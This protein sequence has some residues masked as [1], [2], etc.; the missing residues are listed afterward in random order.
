MLYFAI[1]KSKNYKEHGLSRFY[2]VNIQKE[3]QVEWNKYNS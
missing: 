3:G 1:K 2:F